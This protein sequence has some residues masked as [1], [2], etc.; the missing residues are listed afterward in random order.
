M[1]YKT[2]VMPAQAGI[3]GNTR[4]EGGTVGAMDPRF[5]EDDANAGGKGSL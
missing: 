5:R 3:H 1:L 2:I 4:A